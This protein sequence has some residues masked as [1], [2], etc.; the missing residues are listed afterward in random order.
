MTM[1]TSERMRRLSSHN[2]FVKQP[3][4]LSRLGSLSAAKFTLKIGWHEIHESLAAGSSCCGVSGD[5]GS[6]LGRIGSWVEERTDFDAAHACRCAHSIV[7][8]RI[9]FIELL[10]GT[11]VTGNADRAR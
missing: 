3:P 8:G 7:S 9:P 2:W 4:R 5:T 1:H 6:W 11:D 10:V